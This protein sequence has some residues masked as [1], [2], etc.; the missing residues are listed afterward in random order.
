L[1]FLDVYYTCI[2]A[3]MF[4][5]PWLFLFDVHYTVYVSLSCILLVH[6][7]QRSR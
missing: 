1:F 5:T 2:F 3:L 4:I 7:D 6:L